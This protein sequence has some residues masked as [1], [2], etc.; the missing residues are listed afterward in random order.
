MHALLFLVSLPFARLAT[1]MKRRRLRPMFR[2][3][4]LCS[5]WL[6]VPVRGED[7]TEEPPLAT[8]SDMPELPTL[9]SSSAT[10]VPS[11][12]AQ[13]GA[14][15]RGVQAYQEQQ[16][17]TSSLEEALS[18]VAATMTAA[19]PW[20]TSTTGMAPF[21]DGDDTVVV[22][23]DVGI[24]YACPNKG[25]E[26]VVEDLT[27]SLSAHTATGAGCYMSYAFKG[28]SRRSGSW[29]SSD[30]MQIYGATGT[31][32]GVFGC[33]VSAS[34]RNYTG[35]WNAYGAS[36][37]FQP[38]QGSCAMQGLGWD[39]HTVQLVNSPYQPGKVWFTGLRFSTNKTEIPWET[40]TWDACC[41]AYTFPDGV[42]TTVESKPTSTAASGS[43]IAGM[44]S[45]T[46]LFVI[47]GLG[48]VIVLASLLVGMMCCKKRP[49]ADG[50]STKTALRKALDSDSD[51]S[52]ESQPLHGKNRSLGRRGRHSDDESRSSGG[53]SASQCEGSDSDDEKRHKKRRHR[54]R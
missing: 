47:C 10:E 52:E 40:H 9:T 16:S 25:D 53:S 44:R 38:Y 28:E 46:A 15:N 4:L 12:P 54:R 6:L 20:A 34:G 39:D 36:N 43:T 11:I 29:L 23:S 48:A 14:G 50:A 26:W 8:L 51:D 21:S 13:M 18:S 2:L 41:A 24:T 49:A 5:A 17:F 19:A 30:G 7:S 22:H 33:S 3:A 37:T 45:S 31:E 35:W 27:D 42:A 32:G 1:V